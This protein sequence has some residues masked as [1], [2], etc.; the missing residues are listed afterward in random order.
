MLIVTGDSSCVTS[1]HRHSPLSLPL[2]RV[3]LFISV[4][5][6]PFSSSAL[7]LLCVRSVSLNHP[8]SCPRF[9]RFPNIVLF[10]F[11]LHVVLEAGTEPQLWRSQPSLEITAE[12]VCIHLCFCLFP[13]LS[14]VFLIHYISF[15][16]CC[17]IITS[18]HTTSVTGHSHLHLK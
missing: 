4:C 8:I 9:R 6:P 16:Y 10:C 3:S 2:S 14:F 15:L 7:M 11:S 13:K 5:L 1:M 17:S 18:S 12:T